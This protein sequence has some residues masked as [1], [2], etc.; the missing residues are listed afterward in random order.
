MAHDKGGRPPAGSTLRAEQGTG[1]ENGTSDGGDALSGQTTIMRRTVFF[2][3]GQGDGE[4]R[5]G[6]SYGTRTSCYPTVTEI[7][8]LHRRYICV[9]QGEV[10]QPGDDGDKWRREAH[11]LLAGHDLDDRVAPKIVIRRAGG[12]VA[13]PSTR[14]SYDKM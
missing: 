6:P 1:R 2:W 14:L 3:G 12:D 4:G 5:A 10:L 13:A 7:P 8:A 11:T 9:E